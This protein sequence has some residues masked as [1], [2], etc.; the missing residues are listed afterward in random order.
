MKFP[1]NNRTSKVVNITSHRGGMHALA[2]A[3]CSG[4]EAEDKRQAGPYKTDL[5]H[6]QTHHQRHGDDI[7][8]NGVSNS[9]IGC[10]A[11]RCFAKFGIR[12]VRMRT[13]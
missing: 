10:R 9:N 2:F 6:V 1:S 12:R 5:S 4:R 13:M 3:I 8:G 7:N 11:W